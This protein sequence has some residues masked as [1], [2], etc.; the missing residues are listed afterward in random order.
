MPAKYLI[1]EVVINERFARSPKVEWGRQKG[2]IINMIN[3]LSGHNLFKTSERSSPLYN[4]IEN[5]SNDSSSLAI[6][7][8]DVDGTAK[9]FNSRYFDESEQN[10]TT[11]LSSS[12]IYTGR[13]LISLF[14]FGLIKHED[15][16]LFS[17]GKE[18]EI[19]EYLEGDNSGELF[20]TVFGIIIS[21]RLHRIFIIKQ[22]S[23]STVGY[24]EL[25]YYLAKK[26]STYTGLASHN[27][28]FKLSP[29]FSSDSF[30]PDD[31]ESISS[32]EV[33]V[34]T[35]L[36]D[37]YSI[38]S[39]KQDAFYSIV[40]APLSKLFGKGRTTKFSIEFAEEGNREAKE[41][42][43]QIYSSFS[44]IQDEEIERI[45]TNFKIVYENT[46]GVKL[47]VNFKR[48]NVYSYEFDGED[49]G[50]DCVVKAYRWIFGILTQPTPTQRRLEDNAHV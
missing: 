16:T 13:G 37:E 3:D 21:E 10:L 12:P 43:N 7:P 36:I 44:S 31:I 11:E 30:N 17:E 50:F 41:L 40:I 39:G 46:S 49:E 18:Q 9:L 34:N 23:N 42:F 35:D 20:K 14:K 1:R 19:W 25:L 38:R 8:I 24:G 48:N 26:S 45:F 2:Y 47:D 15:I 4:L 22:S 5:Y 32:L 33:G 29:I 27:L 6:L 28:I